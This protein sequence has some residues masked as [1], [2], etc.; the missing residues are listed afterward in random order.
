MGLLSVRQVQIRDKVA[1]RGFTSLTDDDK[2]VIGYDWLIF[3]K[4][5]SGDLAE[6]QHAFADRYKVSL[7][8]IIKFS[9]RPGATSLYAKLSGTKT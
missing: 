1:A 7:I 9:K 2:D 5:L 3:R 6:A 8:S 4:T